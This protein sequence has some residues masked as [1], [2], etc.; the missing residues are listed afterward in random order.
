[1]KFEDNPN[2]LVSI[3]ISSFSGSNEISGKEF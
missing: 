1:M 3:V 2:N